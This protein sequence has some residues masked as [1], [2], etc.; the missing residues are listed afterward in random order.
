MQSLVAPRRDSV[1]RSHSAMRLDDYEDLVEQEK[2]A[3]E[4]EEEID[5]FELF[6]KQAG[7]RKLSS[8]ADW[9]GSLP[10][11]PKATSP[12]YNL[13]QTLLKKR[14]HAP[15]RRDKGGRNS[16]HRSKS[17]RYPAKS[18]TPH[19][20]LTGSVKYVTDRSVQSEDLG[21]QGY[22]SVPSSR[23][24][25]LR[26]SRYQKHHENGSE[27]DSR[28][29]SLVLQHEDIPDDHYLVRQ[30]VTTRKGIV[31]R[32]DSIRSCSTSSVR[33]VGS[34]GSDGG[35]AVHDSNDS[36]GSPPSGIPP[37]PLT[38]SPEKDKHR[39]LIL[40]PRGVGKT[41]LIKQFRSTEC[42]ADADP[43]F[44]GKF[45]KSRGNIH[46]MYLSASKSDALLFLLREHEETGREPRQ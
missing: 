23:S 24:G 16:P 13:A 26:R 2:T 12:S 15:L 22:S 37:S 29:D 40:G 42:S 14:L 7:R 31:N 32:G 10:D 19:G 28:P 21:N 25:S 36:D 39:V 45:K 20:K 33:S 35:A 3:R 46:L 38:V 1:V 4:E 18:G 17:L 11:I 41:T 5:D 34:C 44:E 30:F 6:C 9:G 8:C 43:I 27:S